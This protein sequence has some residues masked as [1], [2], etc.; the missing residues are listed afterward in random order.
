MT[1][2]LNAPEGAKVLDLGAERVARAEARAAA[3]VG[4]PFLKLAAG[5]VEIKPEMPLSVA[6]AVQTDLKAGLAGL[7]ADPSDIDALWG[8]G[9]SQDDIQAVMEFVTGRTLG[10]SQASPTP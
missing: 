3:G 8:D 10:E 5:Y 4:A 2:L 9:L 7:L 1:V 6:E